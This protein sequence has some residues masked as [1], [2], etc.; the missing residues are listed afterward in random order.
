MR[1]NTK[2]KVVKYV[3]VY[4]LVNMAFQLIAPLSAYALTSGPS[5]PEVQSFTPAGTS[6]MVDLFSGKLNYNIPLFELPGPNGSYPFN[7]A[8]TQ[9]IGMDQEASWVG[10]GWNVNPGAINRTVRGLPDDFDGSKG[11]KVINRQHMKPNWTVGV[12]ASV[13][14][15]FFGADFSVGTTIGGSI[16]YNSYKGIGMS[17]DVGLQFHFGNQNKAGAGAGL[18]LNLSQNSQEGATFKPSLSLTSTTEDDNGIM[19]SSSFSLAVGFNT[20]RGLTDLS[21]G[22]QFS[23]SATDHK[24][25]KDENGNTMYKADGDVMKDE[26]KPLSVNGGIGGSASMSF[27]PSAGTPVIN[28]EM[29]GSSISLTFQ[30][31]PGLFGLQSNVAV[32]G[33]YT[34]QNLKYQNE[35]VYKNAYGYL[36][37]QNTVTKRNISLTNTPDYEPVPDANALMDF[38]REKDGM[39]RDNTPNLSIPNHTF[40]VYNISGQG[41]GGMFRAHRTHIVTLADPDKESIVGG[42]ALGFKLGVGEPIKVGFNASINLTDSKSDAEI[43]GG[44]GPFTRVNNNPSYWGYNGTISPND[45]ALTYPDYEQ[46]YFK[47]NG[48]YTV[49]KQSDYASYLTSGTSSVTEATDPTSMYGNTSPGYYKNTSNLNSSVRRPRNT[50]VEYFTFGQIRSQNS[51]SNATNVT[52]GLSEFAVK[53]YGLDDLNGYNFPYRYDLTSPA[54]SVTPHSASPFDIR[55]DASDSVINKDQHIGAFTVLQADGSRYVYALPVYNFIQVEKMFSVD[56]DYK[57]DPNLNGTLTYRSGGPRNDDPNWCNS[58]DENSDQYLSRTT[59]QNY[60]SAHL[61]TAILGPDYVDVDGNGPSDNDFGHWVKF[62]YVQVNDNKNN[63]FQ[64]RAPYQGINFNEGLW[65]KSREDKKASIMYGKKEVYYL[66]SAE[67]KT[68]IAVFSISPRSDSRAVNSEFQN[69]NATSDCQPSYK[70]DKISLYSKKDYYNA[71]RT[72]NTNALALTTVHFAYT[73]ELCPGIPNTL[74]GTD[75]YPEPVTIDGTNYTTSSAI[76][77]TG[78]L[79]LRKLWFTYENST[80]GKFNP[81]DF[82]YANA[83]LSSPL[84]NQAANTNPCNPQYDRYSQD[85]WGNYKNYHPVTLSVDPTHGASS[86]APVTLDDQEFPYVDQL[87]PKVDLDNWASAWSLTTI[88]TPSGSTLNM[89]YETDDYAYVQNKVAG[90]MTPIYSTGA[91]PDGSL[92]SGGIPSNLLYQGRATASTPSAPDPNSTLYFNLQTPI[93]TTDPNSA[94]ELANYFT[95]LETPER[96]SAGKNIWELYYKVKL[97]LRTPAEEPNEYVS[98]YAT[99]QQGNWGFDPNSVEGGSY[100][101]A[102]VILDPVSGGGQYSPYNPIARAGWEF[103]QSMLPD[104][105]YLPGSVTSGNPSS[106]PTSIMESLVN[107]FTSF[108]SFFTAYDAQAFISGWS[109]QIDLSHSWIRLSSPNR[110]KY[111]GGARVKQVTLLDSWDQKH[112]GA[113][114]FTQYGVH[115]NYTT[116][117]ANGNTISSGVAAY[118]PMLGGDEIS[119]RYARNYPEN[120]P[121]KTHN[122]LY[123]EYPINESFYPGP[124]VGYSKVT[125]TSLVANYDLTLPSGS[126]ASILPSTGVTV[127]EFYT[128]KDFPVIADETPIKNDNGGPTHWWLPIPFLG[129]IRLDNITASQG[130][131]VELNDMH[132]KPKKTTHYALSGSTMDPQPVSWVQYD[133][134]ATPQTSYDGTPYYQVNSL[135]PVLTAD[136]RTSPNPTDQSLRELGVDYDFFTDMRHYNSGSGQGGLDFNADVMEFGPVIIPAFVPWPNIS[137]SVTVVTSQTANKIIHR[138]GILAKTTAYDGGSVVTTQNQKYDAL[139]GR[140]LLTTVTNDFDAPIYKY[141]MPAHWYYT[142]MDAASQNWGFSQNATYLGPSNDGYSLLGVA[143]NSFNYYTEGDELLISDLLGSGH[144][145][146][147]ATVIRKDATHNQ[148]ICSLIGTTPNPGDILTCTISRSGHRNQIIT[149]AGNITA[150]KDPT[151][152][153]GN[154]LS[155]STTPQITGATSAAGTGSTS[156]SVSSANP[157]NWYCYTSLPQPQGNVTWTSPNFVDNS[158]YTAGQLT[159]QYSLSNTTSAIAMWAT[160]NQLNATLATEYNNLNNGNGNQPVYF[161][162]QIQLSPQQLLAMQQPGWANNNVQIAATGYNYIQVYIDGYL[163]GSSTFPSLYPLGSLATYCGSTQLPVGSI[164]NPFSV[165]FPGNDMNNR[166]PSSYSFVLQPQEI[167]NAFTTANMGN[168]QTLGIK[169]VEVAVLAQYCESLRRTDMVV[170]HQPCGVAFNMTL[171][172][173]AE[174]SPDTFSLSC[175]QSGI[176]PTVDSILSSSAVRYS[177]GW[178][179]DFNQVRGLN[180]TSLGVGQLGYNPYSLGE[181]GI[182][183]PYQNYVYVE[184]RMQNQEGSITT[185]ANGNA[186]IGTNISRD[187]TFDTMPIFQWGDPFFPPYCI[188]QWRLTNTITEYSPLGY[189]LE[190]KNILNQYSSALYS[191]EGK[192]AAAVAGNARVGEVAMEGFE[193][194]ANNSSTNISQPSNQNNGANTSN[195][196]SQTNSSTGNFTFLNGISGTSAETVYYPVDVLFAQGTMVMINM[197]PLTFASFGATSVKI[198]AQGAASYLP[199]TPLCNYEDKVGTYAVTGTGTSNFVG[200]MMPYATLSLAAPAPGFTTCNDPY[201]CWTGTVYIPVSRP[202]SGSYASTFVTK[203]AHT[204]AACMMSGTTEDVFP[205]YDLKLQPDSQYVLSAWVSSPFTDG[206]AVNVLDNYIA[207]ATG[208]IAGTNG[209]G[210]DIG[211]GTPSSTTM[212][213]A[214]GFKTIAPIPGMEPI[215]GWRRVTAIIKV[216]H[217]L[218]PDQVLHIGIRPLQT[219]LAEGPITVQMYFDDFRIEPYNASLKTYVYDPIDY[220]LKAVLDENNH[221][222]LYSYDAQGNLFLVKKETQ[223]GI[224]TVQESR[225]NIQRR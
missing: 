195:A 203:R 192:L 74:T 43:P 79:T 51:P 212:P 49:E 47:I 40:D 175:T 26:S 118:E 223:R 166:T 225:S 150:I 215:E 54:T 220:K 205:Q 179:L 89:A 77:G 136:A 104:I 145:N 199:T 200:S 142:G 13:S 186:L 117:D 69:S 109:D 41:V 105:A 193:E 57:N 218:T 185:L 61:L 85:R 76:P 188:P 178:T 184:N 157:G 34:L 119:L 90:V 59:T 152:R 78:K 197:D 181:K 146:N 106:D 214:L 94:T 65:S 207:N 17:T 128:A 171:N 116:T 52:N 217:N 158:T 103:L 107:A 46:V 159:S 44:S 120:V 194:Y 144:G 127:N 191:Y 50:D 32:G 122:D 112:E 189:E 64:W 224:M 82:Y 161:R 27:A 84:L 170:T 96:N 139:T 149:D 30:F 29:T 92:Y 95:S 86:T 22:M 173:P 183:R 2:K 6:D 141:N 87:Q 210:I 97:K 91:N 132:G 72:V 58:D 206:F 151:I 190:N 19:N 15:E 11:D 182:F 110:V 101:R 174:T 160:T 12:N 66:A 211:Y 134:Q 140:P 63:P 55:Y 198:D 102:F 5:T 163:R 153:N 42:G 201:R 196:I 147:K 133:Y 70:L 25:Q 80:K 114:D 221:A 167:L 14:P 75:N 83:T 71:D 115:Y 162:T 108:T 111:G 113:S 48:E 124:S 137:A 62:N 168:S 73:Y 177:D 98:G 60:T 7:L 45:P 172:F 156:I 164:A 23:Q 138:S 68:H 56:Y 169:T 121:L 4:L 9:G 155:C 28:Q 143:S 165:S 202:M 93:S 129:D 123:F 39:I 31:G 36:Y 16:F 100:T 135:V 126:T 219:T 35:D 3:S 131:K 216:P 148:L 21:I 130:Y 125:V 88:Q 10:L 208:C 20:R 176:Y 33:Y 38:N 209:W 8:Y 222:A 204:G 18:G 37:T 187:G 154:T 53:T 180:P 24:A 1:I 67:T 99:F 213:T 81:Y